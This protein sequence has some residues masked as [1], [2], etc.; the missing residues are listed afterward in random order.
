MV[1]KVALD[2]NAAIALLNND[3]QTLLHLNK[4]DTIYLPITFCG[5]LLFGAKNSGLAARNLKKYK[6]FIASCEPLNI[7]YSVADFYSSIRHQ[8]KVK[9]KPIPENDVWIAA[10][11]VANKIPLLT[12]DKH[13]H[14][15]AEL[16]LVNG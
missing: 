13:F 6:E 10:T 4:F 5:E 12:Y 15:V 8:L 2:T 1:K 11:C 16:K 3:K 14:E 9:G 7:D